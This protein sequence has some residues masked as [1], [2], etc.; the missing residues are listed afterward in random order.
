[1][2]YLLSR[3]ADILTLIETM[4]QVNSDFFRRDSLD[5]ILCTPHHRSRQSQISS[6]LWVLLRQRVQSRVPARPPHGL[7]QHPHQVALPVPAQLAPS[8]QVSIGGRPQ[9]HLRG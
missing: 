9:E 7:H 8:C 4:L 6:V 2:S 1:M 5:G 3:R